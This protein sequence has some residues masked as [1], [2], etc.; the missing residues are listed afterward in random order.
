[1]LDQRVCFFGDSFVQG[2][3]D[4]TGLGWVGR[5]VSAANAEHFWL[6]A[7]NLGI[8][9]ETS[10]ELRARW[11]HEAGL[12][13]DGHTG[14]VVFSFGANDT[15]LEN[16][17]VRVSLQ[18]TLQNARAILAEASARYPTFMVSPPAL[19]DQH[20]NL[21]LS[22]LISELE[23]VCQEFNVPFLNMF[24]P[25]SSNIT[26]MREASLGDGFHPAANGYSAYAELVKAWSAWREWVSVIEQIPSS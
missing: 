6:T 15:T 20:Q 12:R 18:Q 25:L 11:E 21:R 4:P 19:P 26:W 10:Q 1:M 8:R 17:L 9:R 5:V 16:G 7:Y 2:T 22:R 13:L 3:G 14:R 23:D 24:Q